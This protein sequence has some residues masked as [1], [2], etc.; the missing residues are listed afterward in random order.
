MVLEA[1][2]AGSAE[3]TVVSIGRASGKPNQKWLIVPKGGDYYA[4][5]PASSPTLVLSAAKGGTR[6]GT[7][8]VL[9]PDQGKPWQLWS[10]RKND[11]GS[12]CLVPQ[13]APDKGLDDFGGNREPGARQD[14]WE[15]RPGDPHLQWLVKPLAGTLPAGGESAGSEYVAPEIQPEAILPGKIESAPFSASR[16]F[17]GTRRQ[18]TVFVPAQYDG[19][20][21]ACVYVKF[22]GYNPNEKRLLERMI[23]TKELPVMVGVFVTPGELPAPLKNTLGRRNRDLEYDGMG[24]KNVRFL[25]EELLPWVAQQWSLKLSPSG[26]DRCI[27]GGSSGGIAAFNAAWERPDAFSR[28]YANSGS[29]VAFRGGHEFPTLVRKTEAKPIRAFLT[30]GTRDME[31]A[32]GDWFLLDQEMDKALRFSG[33]DYRFHILNGGHVAGYYDYFPEAMSYLWKGWPQ[34]VQAGSSAPRARDVLVSDEGWQPVNWPAAAPRPT[35]GKAG[36]G[37]TDLRGAAVNAAGEVFFL[38]RGTDRLYRIASDG[39]VW[40]VRAE[41]GKANSLSFGPHGELYAVSRTTGKVMRYDAAGKGTLVA[42]GL[43]GEYVLAAP[44]GGVYVTRN[45]GGAS[46]DGGEVWFLKDGKKRRVASGLKFATG[47]AYR[48]DQWLLAVAEGHSKWATSYQIEA[49]GSLSHGE[50]YFWLHVPDAEDDAGTEAAC[51]AREGQILFATRAGIQICADDG[52]TQVILPLPDRG[53]VQ[54]VCL[55]GPELDTLYAFSGGRVWKRKVKIHGTGAF[56]PW[57]RVNGTPL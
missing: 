54:G 35:A 11:N 47:L 39:N 4:L 42:S 29:F 33:Y 16:I 37:K 8:I 27:A 30:T 6:N 38:D 20:R 25:T 53:R 45:S 22:D 52:P 41:T 28:V 32:A 7:P 48:P 57:T 26:N 12:Y 49:D 9:E 13:H 34:P 18:V 5:R 15:N 43:P 14:L 50:R 19:S 44:G 56:T 24:D 40:E 2:G 1:V 10:L 55:G 51:Y 23:A 17:P 3:G 31:N 21:P 36:S 46:A